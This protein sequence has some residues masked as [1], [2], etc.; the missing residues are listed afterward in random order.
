MIRNLLWAVIAVAVLAT[1]G[2]GRAESVDVMMAG[3]VWIRMR[4]PAG[5]YTAQ[6]RAAIVQNRVNDLLVLGGFDLDTLR[7]EIKGAD[8]VL[9]AAGKVLVT[10]DEPTARANN[11][12][13]ELL[14]H[15][16]AARF[17]DIYPRIVPTRPVGT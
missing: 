12:T 11:T 17:R 7:V 3:S 14:A 1:A 6:Q 15:I 8:A 10:V 13:P 9:R 4:C 5:G 16:W 2:P